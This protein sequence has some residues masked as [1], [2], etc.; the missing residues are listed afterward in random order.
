[1]LLLCVAVMVGWT[2]GVFVRG[3]VILF[4]F[5]NCGLQFIWFGFVGVVVVW[6]LGSVDWFEVVVILCEFGV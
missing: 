2:Y 5:V 6:A 4:C 1:M 3:F